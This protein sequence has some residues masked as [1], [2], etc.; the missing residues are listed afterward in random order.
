MMETGLPKPVCSLPRDWL[1][2][3]PLLAWCCLRPP[4]VINAFMIWPLKKN[5]PSQLFNHVSHQLAEAV[6]GSYRPD[7]AS[8]GIAQ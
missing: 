1:N 6:A 7:S 2:A 3:A 4:K 8:A 5:H